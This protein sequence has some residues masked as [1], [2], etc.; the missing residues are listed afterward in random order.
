MSSQFTREDLLNSDKYARERYKLLLLQSAYESHP[1]IISHLTYI[2]SQANPE[3]D[4]Y[5]N[6]KFKHK[7]ILVTMEM[8]K[9]VCEKVSCFPVNGEDFCTLYDEC[10]YTWTGTDGVS[11]RRV[12]QPSCYYL[13]HETKQQNTER[14]IQ[15]LPFE[16]DDEKK[17]CYIL[18]LQSI[19]FLEYPYYRS[20]K[21]YETRV[22]DLKYGFD[23]VDKRLSDEFSYT[24]YSYVYNKYYCD[25]YFDSWDPEEKTCYTSTTDWVLGAVIGSTLLKYIKAKYQ[26]VV[27]TGSTYPGD[28][29]LP[30]IKDTEPEWLLRGW[31]QDVNSNFVTPNPDVILGGKVKREI[32]VNDYVKSKEND[33]YL[34]SIID[35]VTTLCTSWSSLP[36]ADE[37]IEKLISSEIV[38]EISPFVLPLLVDFIL[39]TIKITFNFFITSI[40]GMLVEVVD[41][42]FL[43]IAKQSFEVVFSRLIMYNAIKMSKLVL[44]ALRLVTSIIDPLQWVLLFATFIDFILMYFDPYNLNAQ[45]YTKE[46]LDYVLL[47]GDTHVG[48]T[49]GFNILD[50]ERLL[51]QLILTDANR[52]VTSLKTFKYLYE[53]LN[54]LDVNSHGTVIDKGPVIL[55]QLGCIPTFYYTNAKAK[56][57]LCTKDAFI[58]FEMKF[59]QRM[60][61]EKKL[62]IIKYTVGLAGIVLILIRKFIMLGVFLVLLVFFLNF[63]QMINV[64]RS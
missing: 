10:K 43:N 20:D 19:L 42:L 7:A 31:L 50:C 4:Y 23:K 22:N 6:D 61:I 45:K 39:Q 37:L 62:S 26:E 35:H 59:K 14:K 8:T 13:K 60:E 52:F 11:M 3:R 49:Y 55:V 64:F 41:T 57:N 32:R 5:Y 30:R 63:L 48:T 15:S 12:C 1:H 33:N 51:L 36:N 58:N 44:G 29:V 28:V 40:E 56:I 27:L 24:P 54:H 17:R 34:K 21:K 25:A 9:Q 38:Q 47:Y 46:Y 18:P 53:Y 16:W 2:V